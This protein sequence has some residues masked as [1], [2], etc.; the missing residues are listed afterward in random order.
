MQ[1]NGVMALAWLHIQAPLTSDP[2]L[3]GSV[4]P[5][6]HQH[7]HDAT[8]I[9]AFDDLVF[10]PWYVSRRVIDKQHP[11]WRLACSLEEDY[12][13]PITLSCF[14]L[15]RSYTISY[16]KFCGD[17][18]YLSQFSSLLSCTARWTSS[19]ATESSLASTEV[20]RFPTTPAKP[21][22]DI[23]ISFDISLSIKPSYQL[24]RSLYWE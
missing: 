12:G 20:Q 21:D 3:H 2:C 19:I 6:D 17:L 1:K 15:A 5:G 13:L 24:P 11:G 10:G 22:W 14:P 9:A 7:A 8:L 18:L 4:S 16:I 23:N